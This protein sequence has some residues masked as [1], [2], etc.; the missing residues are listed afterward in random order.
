MVILA[1]ETDAAFTAKD[2][3]RLKDHAWITCKLLPGTA[4]GIQREDPDAIVHVALQDSFPAYF[5]DM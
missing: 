1:A 4:H 5:Q 3:Q 2:A